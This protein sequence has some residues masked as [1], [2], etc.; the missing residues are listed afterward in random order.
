MKTQNKPLTKAQMKA[1]DGLLLNLD[2]MD[3][4]PRRL[5]H[6][7]EDLALAFDLKHAVPSIRAAQDIY[8]ETWSKGDL[9]RRI[10]SALHSYKIKTWERQIESEWQTIEQAEDRIDGAKEFAD[11]LSL[12]IL[13]PD[14]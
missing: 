3:N 7:L 11:A 6:A 10:P 8:Y 9:L 13:N 4:K 14:Y 12:A 2:E 1:L 5:F